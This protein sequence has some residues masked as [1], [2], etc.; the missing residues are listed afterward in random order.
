MLKV[1]F[2]IRI[3]FFFVGIMMMVVTICVEIYFYRLLPLFVPILLAFKNF[4][5]AL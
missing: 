3:I 2:F 4:F 1:L 5:N